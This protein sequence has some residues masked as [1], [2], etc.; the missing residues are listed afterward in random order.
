MAELNKVSD[1]ST[2]DLSKGD[3]VD[4]TYKQWRI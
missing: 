3:I 1:V 4:A 2:L